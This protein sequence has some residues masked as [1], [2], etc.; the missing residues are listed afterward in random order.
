MPNL[1]GAVADVNTFKDFLTTKLFVQERRI[2]TLTDQNATRETIIS[3]LQKLAT[4]NDVQANQ[5]IIIFY[6]GH[7]SEARKSPGS[8]DWV[9]LICPYD[10]YPENNDDESLQ[11]I[12]DINLASLLD[13]ISFAKGNN[14]VS[15]RS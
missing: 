8:D 11:G 14:I 4:S 6:S 7:G 15:R 10:F 2:E 3:G 13:Q 12:T 9:E 1:S 5:P